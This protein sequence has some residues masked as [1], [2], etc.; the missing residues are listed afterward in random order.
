[1]PI[2]GFE[3]A[4]SPTRSQWKAVFRFDI[5]AA[6]V[7]PHTARGKPLFIILTNQD[8]ASL[9]KFH[10]NFNVTQ[11]FSAACC[12]PE[13][14]RLKESTLTPA[15][16]SEPNP[17]QLQTKLHGLVCYLLSKVE[18]LGR[19][20]RYWINW[21]GFHEAAIKISQC[22]R[23][24]F[25]VFVRWWKTINTERYVNTAK[26]EWVRLIKKVFTKGYYKKSLYA[27]S[28]LRFQVKVITLYLTIHPYIKLVKYPN[29][30]IHKSKKVRKLH[31]YCATNIVTVWYDGIHENYLLLKS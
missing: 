11:Y 6:F 8:H 27:L 17:R 14:L 3:H 15:D 12:F 22:R 20:K 28:K 7:S 19:E 26:I 5:K 24:H 10:Y 18:P 30:I 25:S 21:K 29:D 4:A 31:N 2:V 9:I 16:V 13:Q 1:M 23:N